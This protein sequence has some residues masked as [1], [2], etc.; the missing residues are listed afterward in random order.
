[1]PHTYHHIKVLLVISKVRKDNGCQKNLIVVST[2]AQCYGPTVGV[3]RLA[4]RATM[5]FYLLPSVSL[6]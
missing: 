4:K 3:V 5:D 6:S 1:M 2:D